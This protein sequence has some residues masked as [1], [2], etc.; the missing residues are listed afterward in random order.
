MSERAARFDALYREKPDPWAFETS[1]YERQKYAATLAALPAGRFRHAI[2]V[3][4]S[5]GVFTR[6]LADRCERVTAL[7]VSAVALASAQARCAGLGVDFRQAEVPAQWPDGRFDL[8]VLSEVLYFLEP[9]EIEPLA[10]RIAEAAAPGAAVLLV[11][12]LGPCDRPLDGA[13]AAQAFVAAARERGFAVRDQRTEPGYRIDL[14]A[15]P[16]ADA[17]L[18]AEAS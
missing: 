7:D 2:E 11:N 13:A 10:Q 8:V 17:A 15:A 12:Y 6:A 1:D 18:P 3:G 5:I 14:L 16:A 9:A 4:C